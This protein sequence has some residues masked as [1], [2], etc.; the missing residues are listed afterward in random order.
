M[1]DNEKDF[2]VA[3]FFRTHLDP[4]TNREREDNYR[5][6]KTAE[7]ALDALMP[8]K[9]RRRIHRRRKSKARKLA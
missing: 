5:L 9:K 6:G 7:S 4:A 8:K 3:K 1:T 2:S